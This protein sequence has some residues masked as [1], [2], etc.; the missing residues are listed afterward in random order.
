MTSSVRYTSS[1][2]IQDTFVSTAVLTPFGLAVW[3]ALEYASVN[4]ITSRPGSNSTH[5][6]LL[7]KVSPIALENF[8]LAM[9]AFSVA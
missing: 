1:Y 7:Y 2:L 8:D 4:E 6:S 3:A 9:L 5:P